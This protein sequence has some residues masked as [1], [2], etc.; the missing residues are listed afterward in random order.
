MKDWTKREVKVFARQQFFSGLDKSDSFLS[1]TGPQ[2]ADLICGM[3]MGIIHDQTQL[4][5]VEQDAECFKHL[6]QNL[7]KVWR[8]K[9]KPVVLNMPLCKVQK[10]EPVDCAYLD[11]LGNLTYEDS[12]WIM[13]P[14]RDLLLPN[15]HV[16]LTISSAYRN[17]QFIPRLT[18]FLKEK[19]PSAY[20]AHMQAWLRRKF[21][22]TMVEACATYELL[23]TYCLFSQYTFDM[24]MYWY[25]EKSS[26]F[27]MILIVM[28]NLNKASIKFTQ[29]MTD[30]EQGMLQII[31]S[32]PGGVGLIGVNVGVRDGVEQNAEPILSTEVTFRMQTA[33]TAGQR[34]YATRLKNEYIEQQRKNGKRPEHIERA[35]KAVLSRMQN[36]AS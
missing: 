34:A 36:A 27:M 6:C 15:A 16:G 24:N 1:L 10:F 33:Q 19:F 17:N 31:N 7:T 18:K 20:S 26:P 2:C 30:M 13:N 3:D 22:N 12:Q 32:R 5:L 9:L 8:S 11:Y 4:T 21:P 25:G 23:L 14:F 28:N 35:F 29:E